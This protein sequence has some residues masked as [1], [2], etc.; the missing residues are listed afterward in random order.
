MRSSEMAGYEFNG[1][2]VVVRNSELDIYELRMAA[3]T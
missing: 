3:C 1:W 2:L